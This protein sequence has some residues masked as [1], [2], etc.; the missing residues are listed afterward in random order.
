MSFATIAP[1]RPVDIVAA[2]FDAEIRPETPDPA[3][4]KIISLTRHFFIVHYNACGYRF[5]PANERRRRHR[6]LPEG[7]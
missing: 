7:E 3:Q 1:M 4:V 6:Y 5:R 2:G